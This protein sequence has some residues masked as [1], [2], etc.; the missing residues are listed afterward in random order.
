ML[1]LWWTRSGEV[2]SLEMGCW[3]MRGGGSWPPPPDPPPVDPP[4][5]AMSTIAKKSLSNRRESV[6]LLVVVVGDGT[7]K[8]SRNKVDGHVQNDYKLQTEREETVLHGRTTNCVLSHHQSCVIVCQTVARSVVRAVASCPDWLYD[9]S[10]LLSTSSIN[11][12][13]PRLVLRISVRLLTIGEDERYDHRYWHHR[14]WWRTI[15]GTT[16]CT[17]NCATSIVRPFKISLRLEISVQ[18]FWTA[19]CDGIKIVNMLVINL[20][21]C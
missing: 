7:S 3:P 9:Q 2:G 1:H 17:T 13:S 8:I 11:L 10:A 6:P 12:Q 14:Y 18:K 19:C 4:L 16:S 15:D 5:F 20:L 21:Y